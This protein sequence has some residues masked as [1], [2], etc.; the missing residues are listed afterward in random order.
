MLE[1][2]KSSITLLSVSNVLWINGTYVS[3][4]GEFVDVFNRVLDVMTAVTKVDYCSY[5][6][7]NSFVTF[8]GISGTVRTHSREVLLA[9]LSDGL[10]VG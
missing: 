5:F 8:S 2:R 7:M 4:L 1:D 6:L 9:D 3:E 10:W